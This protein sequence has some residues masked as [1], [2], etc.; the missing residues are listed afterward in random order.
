MTS[1]KFIVILLFIAVNAICSEACS[2][3]GCKPEPKPAPL[4]AA[5]PCN[6]QC[7]KPA[8]CPVTTNT[9]T[10][11]PAQFS[12]PQPPA[13]NPKPF[14][15]QPP[16]YNP[17]SGYNPA[18]AQSP[19]YN[20]SPAY[21][22]NSGYNPAPAQSPGYNPSPAQNPNS[23]YNP[24]PAQSPGYNPSPAQN[25]NSGYNPLTPPGLSGN[26]PGY[27]YSNNPN[28]P[29]H[30]PLF[31]AFHENEKPKNPQPSNNEAEKP[32]VTPL[33]YGLEVINS[34]HNRTEEG[35]SKHTS[36]KHTW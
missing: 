1:T 26:Y 7:P 8:P 20:P 30:V 28:H 15:Y 18:P 34:Q 35:W 9:P 31:T 21:N 2:G 16:A 5:P 10:Y 4:K 23:G 36:S 22:P 19:G 33:G 27:Q 32:T 12:K 24:A 17:N 11:R 3:G 29:S 13:Q 25:P 6:C 14:S